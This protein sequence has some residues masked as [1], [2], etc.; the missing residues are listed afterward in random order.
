MVD[1]TQDIPPSYIEPH[2]PLLKVPPDDQLLYKVMSL[3]NLLR[4]VA[5]FYLHF[6][7]V[8][9]YRDFHGADSHDGEQTPEDREVNAKVFFSANPDWSWAD[10]CD[11][12]RGRTY[13]CCFSL[14]NSDYIWG[15][16]GGDGKDGKICLVFHF[17]KLKR[18][19]NSTLRQKRNSLLVNRILCKQIFSV[20]YGLVEYD[21]WNKV[22]KNDK[23]YAN[24]ILY[25]YLKDKMF[26]EEKELR[27]TLSTP[28]MGK[29][30]LDDGTLIDFQDS[31]SFGFDFR[32]AFGEGTIQE[33]LC[34][35]DCDTV[36][37]TTE[38]AK[39]GIQSRDGCDL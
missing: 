4:S 7:R 23:Y 9:S 5:G 12:V 16:F 13:A 36:F 2:A 25:A 37:L 6:N 33:I 11:R 20:N 1:S 15:V 26:S 19:I 30:A 22:Q 8:D 31:L 38:L 3:K 28:V 27:V 29:Y 35:P 21:E 34:S 24:P 18:I 17:A 10:H 14:K 32:A 39:L